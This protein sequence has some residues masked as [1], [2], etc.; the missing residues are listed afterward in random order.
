MYIATPAIVE[1]SIGFE[2]RWVEG[3]RVTESVGARLVRLSQTQIRYESV[4]RDLEPS[5]QAWSG[6]LYFQAGIL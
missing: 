6:A 3:L 4:A 1:E 5:K 2:G